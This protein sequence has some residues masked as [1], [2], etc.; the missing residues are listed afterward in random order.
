MNVTFIC[1]GVG[2]ISPY[3]FEFEPTSPGF[4]LSRV[5]NIFFNDN[6]ATFTFAVQYDDTGDYSC[7]ISDSMNDTGVT[8][9]S[10]EVGKFS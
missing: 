5:D 7:S 8:F 1:V 2:G 4:D 3:M 6:F 10:I 9:L